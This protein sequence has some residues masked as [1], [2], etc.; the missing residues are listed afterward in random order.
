MLLWKK[1][2]EEEKAEAAPLPMTFADISP[3]HK[4][5]LI[6][7]MRTDRITSALTRYVGESMG[8]NYIE[9]GLFDINE[10]YE[11]SGPTTPIFFVLFPGVDPTKDVENLGKKMDIVGKNFV[12]ISMG[13]GQEKRALDAMDTAAKKGTWVFLQNVHLMEDWLKLFER[14]LEEVNIKAKKTFRCFISSE[15][16]PP[17]FP[18]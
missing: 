15:P 18:T 1:W 3:F 4:L 17:M 8:T 10:I 12:N 2:F 5:M 13:Q 11:E 16:P 14:K 7:I 6:K 9:Q